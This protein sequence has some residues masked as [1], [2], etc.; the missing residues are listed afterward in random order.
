MD[1]RGQGVASASHKAYAFVVY[2]AYKL[3]MI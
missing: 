2:I 3:Y 1:V